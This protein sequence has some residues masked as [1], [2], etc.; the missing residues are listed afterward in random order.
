MIYLD[1][2]QAFSARCLIVTILGF[3]PLT[4]WW[5]LNSFMTEASF[6]NSMRSLMLADS[7]TVFIATRVSGSSLTTPLA[8]PSY[9]MPKEPWPN[10]L[11]IVIFSLA[12]S[13][14]SGTYTGTKQDIAGQ[15]QIHT[16]NSEELRRYLI[17][18]LSAALKYS[19]FTDAYR[20]P[21]PSLLLFLLTRNTT[22]LTGSR[23]LWL[24]MGYIILYRKP[25]PHHRGR[26]MKT[27]Y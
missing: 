11:C 16:P 14:S 24:W 1:L 6:K 25:T 8:M 7:L 18:L 4:T 2:F 15:H 23:Q 13:H 3:V 5:Q 12:T 17:F 22:Q 9:T 10:S 26:L 27:T 21:F 20:T 19:G